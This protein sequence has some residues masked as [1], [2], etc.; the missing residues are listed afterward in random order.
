MRSGVLSTRRLALVGSIGP[1]LFV[2]IAVVMTVL[3]WDFLHRLGW[4]L[5]QGSSVPYPSATAMGPYGLLQTLNFI[6]VGVSVIAIAIALWK[7]VL[8]RPRVGA[9]LVFLAGV[10]MVLAMFTTDGTTNQPT[11][12]HGWI[13]GL[14]FLL[15]LF[16]TLLGAV[17][18]AVQLR[19]IHRLAP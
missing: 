19:N 13:H 6:Q 9:G 7:T 8:P 11:T 16:S 4:H 15:L 18:L 3:E 5:M 10:A 2:A 17:A 12:W 1:A 14:S